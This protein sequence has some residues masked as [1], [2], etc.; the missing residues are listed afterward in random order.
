LEVYADFE[1]YQSWAEREIPVVVL[2]PRTDG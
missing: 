2:H 1:L